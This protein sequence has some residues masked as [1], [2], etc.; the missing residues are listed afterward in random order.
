MDAP[1]SRKDTIGGGMKEQT[2]EAVPLVKQHQTMAARED[3]KAVVTEKLK[4]TVEANDMV[5]DDLV[6]AAPA[7]QEAHDSVMEARKVRALA[8]NIK[9]LDEMSAWEIRINP[10]LVRALMTHGEANVSEEME[11]LGIVAA[12]MC[13]F[14]VGVVMEPPEDVSR[15]SANAFLVSFSGTLCS[16]VTSAMCLIRFAPLPRE[17]RVTVMREYGV[18]LWIPSLSLVVGVAFLIVAMVDVTLTMHADLYSSPVAS[19]AI[20]TMLL[21]IVVLI[22]INHGVGEL[23]RKSLMR[24]M[25]QDARVTM[26]VDLP[27]TR[28]AEYEFKK[29][30]KVVLP[31]LEA[32]Y[33]VVAEEAELR[34][35]LEKLEAS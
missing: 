24:R 17:D 18:F 35:E 11:I 19:T 8:Q 30:E 34:K 9:D 13:S 12:L 2:S 33:S 20:G 28:K 21:C 7:L 26:A 5:G 16:T 23:S 27:K 4:R 32:F 15:L 29:I 1:C 25:R 6:A 22:W 10:W 31:K 3:Y 14:V